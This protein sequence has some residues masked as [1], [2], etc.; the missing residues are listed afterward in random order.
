MWNLPDFE[1]A[2]YG[3]K[4][5]RLPTV[6][7]ALVDLGR[8]MEPGSND[9]LGAYTRIAAAVT[10]VLADPDLTPT[11]D[12]MASLFGIQGTLS[13]LFR[14]SGFR[15]SDHLA[16]LK[17]GA[18]STLMSVD[19]DLPLDLEKVRD[20]AGPL[21]LLACLTALATVPLLTLKGEARREGFLDL[22]RQGGLGRIP[23]KMGSLALACNGWMICSYALSPDK[24]AIKH[25]LNR[26]FR[27]FLDMLPL[28]DP[29]LPPRTPLKPRPTLVFAAEVIHSTHV[30]YR[31]Y[32]QYL[33]QLRARF[34]LVLVAPEPQVD[35]LVRGLFDEVLVFAPSQNGQH[36]RDA[37]DAITGQQPDILVWPSLGMSNWGPPLANLRLAPIQIVAIGH[38]ASTF[39]PGID[40]MLL[41][42]GFFDDPGQ[43]SERLILLPDAA[44][45]LEPPSAYMPVAPQIRREAAPLR[46]ALPCSMVKLNPTYVALLARLRDRAAQAGRQIEYHL[47]PSA[48]AVQTAAFKVVNHARLGNPVIHPR[49]SPQEYL[50]RLNLCD[51]ALS[52]FPFGGFHSVIDCLRQG[53]PVVAMDAPG[54]PVKTD[55]MLLGLLGLPDWL[56]ATDEA[57]YEAAAL[58]IILDDGLRLELSQRALD[59]RIDTELFAAPGQPLGTE[60]ADA[61]WAVYQH[62]E[63]IQAS[64]ARA[65]RLTELMSL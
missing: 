36:L 20:Q 14:A 13:N 24:H 60:V 2:C 55:R 35:D 1:A 12:Q 22:I 58:K 18:L 51:M 31:Y 62:H 40:Y 42:E 15:G 4:G 16:T 21:S 45:R 3:P 37:Y 33:R 32:G 17:S 57:G 46:V 63:T 50:E 34:R 30:Q 10:A 11:P 9:L 39:I 38:P 25:T 19:T 56:V 54:N 47:F 64:P 23:A 49:L 53:L 27:D 48:A 26:A 41:E 43:F 61:L 29:P 6:F 7:K 52:P 8:T 28:S 59:T 44:L 5:E 65:F